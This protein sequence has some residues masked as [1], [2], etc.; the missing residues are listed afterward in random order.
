MR[1]PMPPARGMIRP[2]HENFE[3]TLPGPIA[4]S[5]REFYA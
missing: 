3:T 5:G 4:S 2:V 1:V